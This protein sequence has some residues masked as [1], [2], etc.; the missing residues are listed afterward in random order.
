MNTVRSA[1]GRAASLLL[2]FLLSLGMLLGPAAS[3]Q[4]QER[5][6]IVTGTLVDAS[7]GVLPGVTV[8]LT[9]IQTGRVSTATTDG[10]G[11]YRVDVEPGRYKVDFALSGFARQEMP[12]VNVLLGREFTINATLKVGNLSEAVQVTAE[13]APLVDTRSTIIAHNVTAEEIDRM[14]KGRSFQ[15]VAMTAPSVNQGEIEGGFQV[16]GASGS[17]NQFTVDGVSTNSLLAGHSRQNTVFE[18]LQEVQV[19]TVGIPAEYG[20]ALG[21]VI[22]AVTK[23]GGNLFTGE[24]HYYYLGSGLSASPVKRLVLSPVD[25]KT[26]YT[27]QDEKMPD[28]RNEVGGSLGGPIVH[29]KLFFFGS[30][31]PR[32]ATKTNQYK[33]SGGTD[34][35][36]IQRDQT[37]TNLYGKVS[38]GGR[39]VNA[40][41]GALWTPTTSK[42]TLPA[43]NGIDAQFLSASKASN[44]VNLVRGYEVDQRNFTGNAD[45]V[46]TNTTFLSMKVGHFHDDY[47]DTG[48]PLTTSWRYTNPC[49][50]SVC[51][52]GWAGPT[53]TQ[54]TPPVQITDFDTTKQTYFQ[55]DY[56]ATFAAAG[57]HTLKA[58]GG[59]RHNSNVVDQRYPGGR[60]ELFWDLTYQ[61]AVPGVAPSRGTYG[62][63]TVDDLGTFG[64]AS[65]DINHFYVQDQWSMGRLTMNLGVRL[66]D[67]KIPA[68]RERKTAIEFG[69]GEKIAPRLGAAYDLFGDGRAKV[70]GS[71][72][73]YFDWTKYELARGTFGGDIWK[74]YYRA[75]DDPNVINNINLSNMPGR[76]ILGAASGF[77]DWRI[78]AFGDDVFDPNLKPMSQDS[79]SAGFEYQLQPTTVL[80]VNYI[81]NDLIR[82]IEDIGRLVDGSEVYTYGNPG[83]GIVE[84]ALLSTAT[85]PFNIP[86]PKRQYDALQVSLNR[87]FTN[88]WFL[89]GSYVLSRLYGNYAGIASSDEIRTPG[90]SSFAVDQQQGAQSSRPGG[91][92]NRAF[93]LDEMMWD[94]HGNLN[95]VG[96]LATDRPH[97]LK[98]YGAYV[99]KFG[100]QIGVNQYVGSGTPLST[101]VRT[102]QTLV[103]A[104]GRGDLGRTPALSTTDLLVSHELRVGGDRRVRF[105]LNVLNVFNQKTVRHRFNLLNR[106]R[107][108]AAINLGSVDLSKGYDY[109]TMIN[110]TP[111]GRANNAIDPRNGQP[112]LWSDGTQGHFMVK[113]LF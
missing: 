107:S 50:G 11:M 57:F 16:N 105:E 80:A 73:R 9:N 42:G 86:R 64:E 100:T 111:D 18:Y 108:A 61:S 52:S 102:L 49:Q 20:G 27:V 63:Y 23:S 89:G 62:Y 69:W 106:N 32:F 103:F 41:F 58:G 97:V 55:A 28:H 4:A 65:G 13:N 3:V 79:Y 94:A 67:E 74:T 26:V 17:E 82:T 60:V 46:L 8:T 68:F 99:T 59:I 24:G 72:G 90:F 37:I 22:S 21:G 93:D 48:V 43:Y 31:S 66:E 84:N 75:L 14:P 78:P 12:D 54:N 29:D 98:A 33:F 77:V 51:P 35:G 2:C 36:E 10:S 81:H 5:T 91:N 30:Y 19:K 71:Y 40:Y 92:A 56:N 1:Q 34:P 109:R 112:D 6:G 38:Y 104:E 53:N 76:D 7:G 95:V 25:D 44:Q 96:R 110:N 47:K 87:R 15:S 88:N 45:I 101:D 39:R 83:E 113:F 85:P 70:F